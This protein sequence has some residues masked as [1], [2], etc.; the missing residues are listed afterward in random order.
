MCKCN[1]RFMKDLAKVRI[2]AQSMYGLTGERQAI[3]QTTAGYNFI[4]ESNSIGKVIVE[5]V[6][7]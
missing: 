3:Y 6:P 2:L 4:S 1:E 7:K 5:Y